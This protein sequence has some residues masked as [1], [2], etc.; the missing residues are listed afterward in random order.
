[1]TGRVPPLQAALGR[2]KTLVAA[3]AGHP[4]KGAPAKAKAPVQAEASSA[5][6]LAETFGLTPFE[7][8]VVLLAALPALEPD[9]GD[10]IGQAQGDPRCACPASAWPFRSSRTATG[11]PSRPRVP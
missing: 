11:A 5:D 4:A 9:A 6:H 7:R 3:A 8:D 10:L 1:M 2:V